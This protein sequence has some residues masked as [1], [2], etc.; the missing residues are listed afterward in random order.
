MQLTLAN[1]IPFLPT[2]ITSLSAVLVILAL[3]IRRS[4][5]ACSLIGTAGL[6]A[7]IASILLMGGLS[8]HWQPTPI[9]N[10]FLID[11][12][13]NLF[14]VLILVSAFAC[15]VL[16]HRFMKGYAGNREELIPLLLI[17]TAG[18]L[19]LVC[20]NHFAAM[21]VG[22]ELMS[23][24]LFALVA[25]HRERAQSLE[26]GVKYLVLSSAASAMLL[27]G[28]AFI[29][30][31]TGS[32]DFAALS[33]PLPTGMPSLP[34][35]L[36]IG[37]LLVALAFKLS[38]AP[39][40]LW[41]PDVYQGA[42]APV[43]AF[44]AS[45]SKLAVMAI[46]MRLVSALAGAPTPWLYESLVV[47]AL[48]SVIGG[49]LL[50]M[51]QDNLKRLLACSSIAHMGYVLT[52]LAAGGVAAN[53]TL[54]VYIVTYL[55]TTLGIFGV[56]SV[57]SSAANSTDTDRLSDYRGLGRQQPALGA[58][59]AVMVLSL[60]GIPLTAGFIGKLFIFINGVGAQE[61]LLVGAVIVGSL[62]GLTYYLKVLVGLYLPVPAEQTTE[63]TEVKPY[64][65]I[66]LGA[67]AFLVVWLG[68]YPQP[69]LE[70]A[71]ALSPTLPR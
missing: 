18:A 20:S 36:G 26:S 8:D 16:A 48:L 56:L 29:Y 43:A 40:H 17:C 44:L 2:A 57:R 4:Q 6:A 3:A 7:A 22:L 66:L 32:M 53:E 55:A 5:R 12:T 69:I 52:A 49:N 31:S 47:V 10:Q 51:R 46:V 62:M 13:A 41:T 34:V 28:V 21:V 23:I 71:H 65:L 30:S 14:M 35:S 59:M 50:A 33:K 15:L 70:L 63:F 9:G 67:V 42:P 11:R 60:A 1:L 24:P 61:W 38:L 45:V 39:F 27:M 25:Y 54:L 64:L 58:I 68:T 37:M 19:T